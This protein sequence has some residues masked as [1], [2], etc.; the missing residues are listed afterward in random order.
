MQV[1]AAARGRYPD[2]CDT[3]AQITEKWAF[4]HI[5]VRSGYILGTAIFAS[6]AAC[7]LKWSLASKSPPQGVTIPNAKMQQR[8]SIS[9]AATRL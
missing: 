4:P 5:Y 2:L 6:L 8:L 3:V 7:L 9:A 1:L